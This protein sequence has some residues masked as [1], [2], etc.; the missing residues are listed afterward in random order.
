MRSQ[1]KGVKDLCFS[2]IGNSVTQNEVSS[3]GLLGLHFVKTGM[4][5]GL[6]SPYPRG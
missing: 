6:Y 5:P 3:K 2:L 4:I 1:V